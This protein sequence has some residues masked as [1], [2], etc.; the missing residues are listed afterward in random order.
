MKYY[1]PSLTG[2][3]LLEKVMVLKDICIKTN[4]LELHNDGNWAKQTEKK[5]SSKKA[6][7]ANH[8]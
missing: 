7:T 3:K 4:E 5:N 8:K 1:Q 6:Y 2:V